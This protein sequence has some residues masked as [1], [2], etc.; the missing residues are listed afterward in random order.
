MPSDTKYRV[1]VPAFKF[2][3]KTSLNSLPHPD[4]VDRNHRISL[5]T[6][7]QNADSQASK[8]LSAHF[9]DRAIFALRHPLKVA[10]GQ[11]F[12][13]DG[14]GGIFVANVVVGA[15]KLP[16]RRAAEVAA[17]A[18]VGVGARSEGDAPGN[19]ERRLEFVPNEMGKRDSLSS[20][21]GGVA[22]AG[23]KGDGLA[24][25]GVFRSDVGITERRRPGRTARETDLL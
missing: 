10:P 7:V 20:V 21:A 16:F 14:P 2:P 18:A 24:L 12:A 19:D 17:G 25:E 11:I 1:E 23:P 5:I 9:F 8:F 4:A 3:L 6:A 13:E 15:D 22:T